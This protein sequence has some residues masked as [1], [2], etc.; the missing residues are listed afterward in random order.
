MSALNKSLQRLSTGL[1]INTGADDPAGLIASEVLRSEI[2]GVK[3]GITNSE[4]ANMMIA[5]AD[6][7]MNQIANLLN[8]IRGLIS[9]AANTGAMSPEMIEANQFQVDASLEAIDRISSSTTFMGRHLLDGSL[10]FVTEGID[11]STIQNL[12]IYKMRF[13]V[14]NQGTHIEVDVR[15]EAERGT[16]YYEHAMAQYA[17]MLQIMGSYGVGSLPI[18][19]GASAASIVDAI[20]QISD[21]TG[22]IAELG[23]AAT[24]GQLTISS[25][26]ENNDILVTATR[27]GEQNSFIE[28]KFTKGTSEGVF[29]EY[30]ESLGEGYPAKIN[31]HLQ[32]SEWEKAFASAVD[33]DGALNNNALDF[34]ANIEGAHY[35]DTT[36]NYV[37][38]Y[39]SDP[40]FYNSGSPK[41]PYAY[42]SDGPVSSRAIVGN[43]NGVGNQFT[44]LTAGDYLMLE[45]VAGGAM[46]NNVKIQFVHDTGTMIPTGSD[47]AKAVMGTDPANP[48]QKVMTVYVNGGTTTFDTIINAINGEGTFKATMPAGNTAALIDIND[49]SNGGTNAVTGNTGNSGGDAGTLFIVG[50]PQ[51][52]AGAGTTGFTAT[53]ANDIVAL[54]DLDNPAS[55]GS[56]RAAALFTVKNSPDNTG[57]GEISSAVFKNIF[58]NGVTGG[59]IITTAQEVCAALNNNALWN[60]YISKETLQ[61]L[62]DGSIPP[63]IDPD[64]QIISSELAPGNHGLT[65]VSSFEEVAYYGSA[66]DGTGLQFLGPTDSR[67]IRFVTDQGNP[68]DLSVDY[69]TVPD[70]EDYARAI[71]NAANANAGVIFTAKKQGEG[72]DDVTFRIK[73]ADESGPPNPAEGWVEFEEGVSRAE[74]Q[75]TFKDANG[76]DLLNSAFYLTAVDRGDE[77]NNVAV[78]MFLDDGQRTSSTSTPPKTIVVEYNEEKK[79]YNIFLNS[80]AVNGL[81]GLPKLTVSDVINA[82]NADAAAGGKFTAELSYSQQNNNSGAAEL[83]TIGLTTTPTSIGNT[84]STGGHTGGTA[85]VYLVSETPTAANPTGAPT[86]NQLVNVVNNDDILGAMFTASNYASGTGAG[87]GAVDFVKDTNFTSSGGLTE[88]G[89]LTVHLATD[90]YGNV[91]T[92]ARDLVA[93]WDTLTEEQTKG[94]S[95]SL[96]REPGEIWDNCYDTAGNGVLSPTPA[97]TACEITT[98]EDIKWNSWADSLCDYYDSVAQY[99]SGEIVAVNGETASYTLTARKPGDEYNGYSISYV[100]DAN[101]TGHYYQSDGITKNE[102]GPRVAVDTKTKKITIYMASG[103]T[104]AN[105]VKALI[106][107]DPATKSLFTVTLHGSDAATQGTGF[108]TV[109]DNTM[110]TK[111]GILPPGYLNGAKLLGGR[112]QADYG[113]RIM[114]S[115]YGSNQSVQII[116]TTGSFETKDVYGNVTETDYG[117]DVDA[118]LNGVQMV[119]NGWNVKIN[120][121]AIEMSFT[122]NEYTTAG[123]LT[124]FD[125][126]GGGATFQL[127]AAVTTNQQITIGIPSLNTAVLG[128]VSGKLYQLKTGNDAALDT[129]T[130]KAYQIV[131]SAIVQVATYRGRLGALQ[132]CTLDTNINVLNDTLEALTSAESQI[133]DTDFAEETS[134]LSRSQVLV[135]SSINAL[136]I[137]NQV[138]QYILGLLG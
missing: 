120:T 136:G 16:L 67:D 100:T 87:T 91:V 131:E 57:V 56:E 121:S 104:T 35:N 80:N 72:Y 135:Q 23:Q 68:S 81:G 66:Y 99:S 50:S 30:E 101:V 15:A 18:E 137:A 29:V 12:E 76:A 49:C 98:Y 79:T 26:G 106:E 28:I 97:N 122:L 14:Q 105:D 60:T 17:A 37:D 115:E 130:R 134:N 83:D 5:T 47:T 42:Y 63:Q 107:N 126:V 34:L 78:N 39:L 117:A 51:D 125:V 38:G 11:R 2:A 62:L 21:S 8:D 20:N 96:L 123:T 48:D 102:D 82:I 129:N 33:S 6:S 86:A 103:V 119:A 70:M 133:R 90:V 113:F 22:V 59:E 55:A 58:Q 64:T 112:D 10:A 74:T 24:N 132:R 84:G 44:N 127:G 1:R 40:E 52:S 114:S 53:T 118:I 46:N 71:L 77:M 89:V 9:E 25:V 65:T 31:V 109:M 128:G 69:S 27:E 7:A 45:A 61:G 43:V 19:K 111:G 110:S 85:T 92:T 3:Q 93:F 36:I 124:A 75:I 95:V 13:G 94:I 4:R 138:P 54:F 73:H 88:K 32:T 116:A 41:S 108:V